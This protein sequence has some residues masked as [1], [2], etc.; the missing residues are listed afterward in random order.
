[1]LIQSQPLD[2]KYSEGLSQNSESLDYSDDNI[3]SQSIGKMFESLLDDNR[4]IGIGL[5]LNWLWRDFTNFFYD[6]KWAIR[7]HYKWRKTMRNLRPWEGFHGFITVMQTHLRDYIETEEKYGH[8][9]EEYKKNKIF[10]AKET[11]DILERMKNP[12]DYTDKRRNE[13]NSRYPDYKTLNEEYEN[14][15]SSFGGDFIEQDK[16]WAGIKGGNDPQE[17]YF[18]FVNER[19]TLV[20]SPDQNET[21]RLL[22]EIANYNKEI[23]NAYEQANSDFEKD[24]DRLGQL[25]KENLYTW[26]D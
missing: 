12:D 23:R 5:R 24:I 9:E 26:W 2:P 11:L 1:M 16:G 8:A 22:T 14:G 3:K 21:N 20:E 25:L 19:L 17:G 6:I 4:K 10:T 15:G 13:V 18:E 7:N